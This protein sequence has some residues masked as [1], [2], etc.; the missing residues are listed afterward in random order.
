[1]KKANVRT[2]SCKHSWADGRNETESTDTMSAAADLKP[3]EI[4]LDLDD[5]V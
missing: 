1:M 2:I 4:D 3:F 5:I